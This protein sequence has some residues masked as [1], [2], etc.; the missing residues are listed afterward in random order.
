VSLRYYIALCTILSATLVGG[1]LAAVAGYYVTAECRHLHYNA[2]RDVMRELALAAETNVLT[3]DRVALSRELAA[4]KTAHPEFRYLYVVRD[5]KVLAHT[6]ASGFPGDL[7]DVPAARDRADEVPDPF[8]DEQGRLAYALSAAILDGRGGEVHAGLDAERIRGSVSGAYRQ[9]LLLAGVFLLWNVG[10]AWWLSGRVTALVRRLTTLAAKHVQLEQ[11]IHQR[12]LT[13]AEL[14]KAKEAAEAASRAKSE[15]LANMSH[16][17]RT[18]M[19][20]ILGMTDLTLDTDLTREQREYLGMVKT[21]GEALLSLLN[22]I[23]DFSKIEAGKLDLD[24]HD[25]RLR[26]GLGDTT[27]ALAMRAHQKGLEL[28]CRIRPDV[29]D[30]LAGDA[31]RLRQVLVNLVGNAI[32]FTDRGEVVI[33]VGLGA[34]SAETVELHFA[35]ADTG[36]GIPAEKQQRIF[37]A[38]TQA[39]GSTTR[40]YG[41][42]GLGLAIS[43]Q[44]IALMGGRIWVESAVGEGSTF[45][46]T[47]RFRRSH[48]AALKAVTRHVD[49][50]G[51]PVLAVDDNATN[52]RILTELLAHWRMA[53][54]AVPSG[55]LALTEL[56]RAAAASEPFPL[57]LIDALMPE[58]DGFALV[59]QIRRDPGLAGATIL[60]LSSADRAADAARCRALSVAVY[61]VKPIKQSELLDA[62][63]TALGSVPLEAAETPQPQGLPV[64]AG[65]RLHLLLAEDNEVNQVLA[66]RTLQKRGHTVVVAANGREALSAWAAE[67]FDAVLMDVQ[68]P[69]MDGLQ[70]TAAI[71]ARERGTGRH[72]PIVALT[73]HVMKGDRERCLEAGMDAYVSKPMRADDL[74]ATLVRL[75]PAAAAGADLPR[76]G[77]G[78]GDSGPKSRASARGM[79]NNGKRGE[80]VFNRRTALEQVEGDC[81]LLRTMVQLFGKQSGNLLAEIRAATACRDGAALELAAHT[82]KGSLGSF[83]AGGAAE[84]ALR[85][86]L[87]GRTGELA[88]ADTA[89]VDLEQEVA[90]L[91]QALAAWTEEGEAL[92]ADEHR[93]C[94]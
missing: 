33:E 91:R 4:V 54:T 87:M 94:P 14:Q 57:V 26:E 93:L 7:L 56:R 43:S 75:V 47:A 40:K 13:E 90:G 80:P 23:L 27:K 55:Y 84:T 5:G 41:G 62:I 32:K 11:E 82:L 10:F 30:L 48:E 37:E 1:G 65:R 76:P 17:I 34:E 16:E 44:I 20:G 89:R 49:L 72:T 88:G 61:L 45:H 66:V 36:L 70:A 24:P 3:D 58:M 8:V 50:E 86:E 22:D 85:L 83:G 68:M 67:S 73:A 2:A 59:E 79:P 77:A 51:L 92:R 31:L 9:V 25:F 71:R 35:V 53:P 81:E 78:P 52:R 42:T 18:P 74:F 60:M 12:E 29:P 46:F 6:F 19:N 64:A 28:A 63:L 21:S 38:F 69:E 15:F 39:D